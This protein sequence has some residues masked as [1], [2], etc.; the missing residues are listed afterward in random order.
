[1]ATETFAVLDRRGTEEL[2]PEGFSLY[3]GS[4]FFVDD[5]GHPRHSRCHRL[6]PLSKAEP[7]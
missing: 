6:Y 5:L 4:L 1:V 3:S 7:L 2:S